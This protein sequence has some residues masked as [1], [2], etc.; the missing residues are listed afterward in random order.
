[1]NGNDRPR[2]FAAAYIRMGDPN[3]TFGHTLDYGDGLLVDVDQDGYLL[4]IELLGDL[5][6]TTA[7]WRI[8][9]ETRLRGGR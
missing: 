7:V 1:M 8:A 5:D 6:P 9:T 4:G 3:R 2:G